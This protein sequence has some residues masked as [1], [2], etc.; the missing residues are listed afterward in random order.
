MNLTHP[1]LLQ[2]NAY[3]W[4]KA[5]REQLVRVTMCGGERNWH[6]GNRVNHE[7]NPNKQPLT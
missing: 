1:N 2:Y 6:K 4:K 7:T 3:I 5:K